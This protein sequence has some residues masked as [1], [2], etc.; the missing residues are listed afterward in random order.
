MAEDKPKKK[1]RKVGRP[2][3]RGRKPSKKKSLKS[4]KISNSSKRGFASALTYNR[5]R[6]ILWEAHK[7][8]YS[9]Y[10]DF[11][12]SKL[13]ANGN[14]IKG[15]S[16]PS[17]VYSEC[18]D[19]GCEEK[20]VLD[21]YIKIQK[22]Q[23]PVIDRGERPQIP[24]SYYDANEHFYWTLHTDNWFSA[25][26][27]DLW[28]YAP[29]FLSNPDDFLGVDADSTYNDIKDRFKPFIN[30]CNKLQV[31]FPSL[32][33]Y[34]AY[35]KF[36]GRNNEREPYWNEEKNRWEVE[37]VICTLSGEID[38]YGFKPDEGDDQ[39][40]DEQKINKI[41]QKE[42]ELTTSTEESKTNKKSKEESNKSY[43][44]KKNAERLLLE[45][46]EKTA[47]AETEKIN[48]ERLRLEQ[49]EKTNK[50]ETEKM[51]VQLKLIE[52]YEKLGFSAE[53]I[54]KLLGL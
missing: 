22:E 5:V 40:I 36:V 2:K 21:I 19:K 8:D 6:K 18:K 12:S 9:S 54:S 43:T 28:V 42:Q 16:I 51:D 34:V 48:A 15:S 26:P 46:Q 23:E 39:Q 17:I 14:K 52:K 13:D 4:K 31:D 25:F 50:S 44:E 35:F 33:N 1:K 3:K 41:I 38:D 29:M 32:D 37:L 24:D 53:K 27:D 11:I 45:Q 10:K 30:Y 7:K 20:D 49:Q 47:K